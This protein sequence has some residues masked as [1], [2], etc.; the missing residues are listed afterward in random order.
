VLSKLQAVA[1]E[2]NAAVNDEATRK[3][4][5]ITWLLQNKL[6]FNDRV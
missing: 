2:V 3:R 6:E 1:E 4:I 5:E